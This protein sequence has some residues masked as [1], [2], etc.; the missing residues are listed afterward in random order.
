MIFRNRTIILQK[1]QN[2]GLFGN[3][4]FS[5]KLENYN[6]PRHPEHNFFR[7]KRLNINTKRNVLGAPSNFHHSSPKTLK[8]KPRRR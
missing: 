2:I 4:L 6:P 1:G 8:R 5:L 7:T 3:L